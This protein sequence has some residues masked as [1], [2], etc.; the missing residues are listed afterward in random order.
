[1]PRSWGFWTS[2][3]LELL[4]RYLDAFTTTTR[5]KS[6]KVVYLDLFAG[7]PENVD[8]LTKIPIDGSP[9]I[10][11]DV[12]DPPFTH[13]RFFEIE[14][15]V[16]KLRQALT[17]E[18]PDRDWLVYEDC[19][20]SIS[21]ALAELRA[22]DAGWAPT[23][24]FIDPNGPHYR[25]KTLETL[26]A[27]K[28]PPRTKTKVEL[29]MLF[30][31][32]FFA[33]LLPTTGDVRPIDNVTITALFGDPSWHAI[34][35]AKLDGTIDPAQARD[36]YV[37]LMRWRLE[38]ELGYRWTHQLE[39]RNTFDRPL[40]HMIFATDSDPGHR[41]MGAIY[42]KAMSEF[43]ERAQQARILRQQRK[44]EELGYYDLFSAA[45][46]FE[47]LGG[48]AGPAVDGPEK[49]YVHEPPEEPREHDRV[50]CTYCEW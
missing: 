10:A 34:W 4:Q 39:V 44:Q 47:S 36:E 33:R 1:M 24:A 29:W 31:D 3:K 25:W 8:R 7:E 28:A 6:T 48:T 32:A 16:T 45:G 14:P 30:P 46:G 2:Y 35:R 11:L 50:T 22:A 5:N 15:N 17:E 42:D 18:F 41:I 40:Y 23:F 49:L 38:T 21:G 26:A 12:A 9:R 20:A 13:L 27:H 37:N 19:N 43:P